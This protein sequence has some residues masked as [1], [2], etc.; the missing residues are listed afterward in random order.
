MTTA[1]EDTIITIRMI[2]VIIITTEMITIKNNY[3]KRNREKS[4]NRPNFQNHK[5]SKSAE[6]CNSLDN[7][8]KRQKFTHDE[9]IQNRANIKYKN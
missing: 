9:T 3:K 6:K 8:N 4:P 7:N 2:I 1:I 5:R